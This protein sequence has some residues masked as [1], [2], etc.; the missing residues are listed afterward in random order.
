MGYMFQAA[1][2]DLLNAQSPSLSLAESEAGRIGRLTNLFLSTMLSVPAFRREV[3]AAAGLKFSSARAEVFCDVKFK[4]EPR[5]PADCEPPDGLVRPRGGRGPSAFFDFMPCSFS[6][7]D[8]NQVRRVANHLILAQE[9]RISRVITISSIVPDQAFLTAVR[10]QLDLSGPDR[11][12]SLTW[13]ETVDIALALLERKAVDGQVGI[14]MLEQYVQSLKEEVVRETQARAERDQGA[15]F[16]TSLGGDWDSFVED[17]QQLGGVDPKDPRLSA[18]ASNWLALLRSLSL[19]LTRSSSRDEDILLHPSVRGKDSHARKEAVIK[20]L[21]THGQLTA[22]FQKHDE[23]MP[24]LMCVDVGHREVIFQLQLNGPSSK[25]QTNSIGELAQAISEDRTFGKTRI[26]IF[27]PT[28]KTPRAVTRQQA[29]KE[30]IA[31][32]PPQHGMVPDKFIV[33]RTVSCEKIIKQPDSFVQLLGLELR[34]FRA[35]TRHL[36]HRGLAA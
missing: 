33:E 12:R 19:Y 11:L 34:G 18:I 35:S 28:E 6:A 10:S 2:A 22:T 27:W 36:L 5:L 7:R 25:S 14:F 24:T 30:P 15:L 1:P 26:K 29:M 17:T 23:R 9:R 13:M 3:L 31:V 16:F 32:A 21:K 20:R 4:D 8:Q